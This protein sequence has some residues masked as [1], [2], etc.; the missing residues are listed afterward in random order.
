M[1]TKMQNRSL[2]LR[3]QGTRVFAEL[4]GAHCGVGAGHR[5]GGEISVTS[6]AGFHS[7]EWHQSHSQHQACEF[8]NA[9]LWVFSHYSQGQCDGNLPSRTV[10]DDPRDVPGELP[11]FSFLVVFLTFFG[12]HGCGTVL[13]ACNYSLKVLLI[14]LTSL[15]MIWSCYF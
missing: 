7:G 2:C 4:R 13:L 8:I 14:F 11:R 12:V 10:S 9:S 3:F 15:Y 1:K 6:R 5:D